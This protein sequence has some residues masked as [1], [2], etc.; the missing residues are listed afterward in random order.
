LSSR[1]TVVMQP[2]GSGGRI[3]STPFSPGAAS[4]PVASSMTRM[5]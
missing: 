1:Q 5:S 3:T 2:G 4:A